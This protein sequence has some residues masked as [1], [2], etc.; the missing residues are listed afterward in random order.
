MVSN[1][2]EVGSLSC[3]EAENAAIFEGYEDLCL[4]IHGCASLDYGSRKLLPP[5]LRSVFE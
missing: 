2:E 5:K 4:V 3:H 1:P